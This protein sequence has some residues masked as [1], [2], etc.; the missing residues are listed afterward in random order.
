MERKSLT[1]LGLDENQVKEV[2]K[3]YNADVDPLQ[4]QVT[5]LTQERDSANSQ[6]EERDTQIK[7]LQKSVTDNEEL[8]SQLKQMQDDN[9]ASAKKYQDQL[10]QIKKDSAIELSLRD[11]KALDSRAVMPF[12]DQ[13]KITV[14]D[15]GKMTGLSEQLEQVKQDKSFLFG[16]AEPD[17]KPNPLKAFPSGNPSGGSNGELSMVQKVAQRLSGN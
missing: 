12:I 11:A 3:L 9:E 14:D 1:D 8:Q 2:M 6:I 13:D 15:D 4:Q 7:D 17:P 16:S 10:A 5:T